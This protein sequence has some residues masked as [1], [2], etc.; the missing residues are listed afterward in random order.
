M[1][2]PGAAEELLRGLYGPVHRHLTLDSRGRLA[3]HRPREGAQ[4]SSRLRLG[5]LTPTVV[6]G[7]PCTYGDQD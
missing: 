5:Q 1:G 2:Q 4:L 7:Q 3:R 6:A